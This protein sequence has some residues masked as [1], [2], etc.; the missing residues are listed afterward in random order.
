MVVL[1]DHSRAVPILITTLRNV[2]TLPVD[3]RRAA[4]R[5]IMYVC[6]TAPHRSCLDLRW[7]SPHSL[8]S[9]AINRILLEEAIA[10]LGSQSA[11][12]TT[13][14]GQE[15]QGLLQTHSLCG[16]A[17]GESGFPFLK[18][19]TQMEPEAA[20]G[21]VHVNL[22]TVSS[23][24][25]RQGAGSGSRSTEGVEIGDENEQGQQQRW[26]VEQADLPPHIAE[27]RVLLFSATSSDGKRVGTAI[28]VL[29]G[30][31]VPEHHICVVT[32][33][34]AADAV[35]TLCSRFPGS[36]PTLFDAVDRAAR[37]VVGVLRCDLMSVH[38]VIRGGAGVK[39][40]AAA[41]DPDVD[42]STGEI[43]PGLGDFV[44]RYN[45]D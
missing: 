22:A 7:M 12:V 15:Y 42:P 23:L 43:L 34:L 3:Y 19:F 35:N 16:V 24:R 4:C 13:P 38:R 30:A 29:L 27:C 10:G 18:F 1:E 40:V 41:I 8:A 9:N 44:A 6:S 5:L 11:R 2:D 37:S 20:R 39:I 31:S 26:Y 17:I 25:P 36:S 45:S 21:F 14:S 33:L 32:V 28:D